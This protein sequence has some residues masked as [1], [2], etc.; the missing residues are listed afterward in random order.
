MGGACLTIF[1]NM[2]A[3]VYLVQSL[4]ILFQFKGT[5]ITSSFE[6]GYFKAD[7]I[8][9]IEENGMQFALGFADLSSLSGV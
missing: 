5:V 4:Q 3:L 6:S 8:Y 9:S 1:A 7:E 2:F